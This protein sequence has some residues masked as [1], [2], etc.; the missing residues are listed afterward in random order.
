MNYFLKI[1][2]VYPWFC[3]L[4]FSID[5]KFGNMLYVNNANIAHSECLSNFSSQFMFKKL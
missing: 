5:Q 3:V 2:I 1:A 4:S